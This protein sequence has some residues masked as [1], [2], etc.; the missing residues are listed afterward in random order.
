M[1]CFS[2]RF[3]Q[4][5]RGRINLHRRTKRKL[6]LLTM[7]FLLFLFFISWLLN[8]LVLQSY[9]FPYARVIL[10]FAFNNSQRILEND[11]LLAEQGWR[12][13]Q[14]ETRYGQEFYCKDK[15]HQK[16]VAW[17]TVLVND[18][19]VVPAL[20]LGHSLRMFSCEKNMLVFV[21]KQVSQPA[22]VALQKVGWTV[23]EVIQMDCKWMEAQQGRPPSNR[24]IAGT[25][26]RFHAW[27]YTQYSKIIYMDPDYMPLTHMDELFSVPGDFAAAYCARP[28]IMDPCFNAGLLVFRPDKDHHRDIINFWWETSKEKCVNDQVLLWHHYTDSKRWIPLPYMYNVRKMLYRPMK[29][30][31]FSWPVPKPWDCAC[32]PSRSEAK[33]FN[34][35]LLNIQDISLLFWKKMYQALERYDLDR[36]WQTSIFF[37][38]SQ[39]HGEKTF[40]EC[41]IENGLPTGNAFL[42]QP[43]V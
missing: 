43:K 41:W 9:F 3:H 22:R 25:H 17:L 23:H 16:D 14:F 12:L 40:N 38:P 18:K 34:R 2:L 33:A 21:S 5:T 35:P 31:H 32:R 39:E 30:F 13:H 36:W 6:F 27:N 1:E 28:G 8:V 37:N 10:E 19:Y 4:W 24:G 42:Y 26:T 15:T 7:L 11:R 20:V 29:A